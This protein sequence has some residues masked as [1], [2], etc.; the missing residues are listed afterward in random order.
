VGASTAHLES[1]HRM[2][3]VE[4]PVGARNG[5]GRG[6][7]ESAAEDGGVPNPKHSKLRHAARARRLVKL[8]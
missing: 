2:T 6:Y 3:G 4:A 7:C 1:R 5:L 8:R